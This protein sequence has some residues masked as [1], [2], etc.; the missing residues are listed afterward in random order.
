MARLSPWRLARSTSCRRIAT[1]R[2]P[3]TALVSKRHPARHHAPK[4]SV[5]RLLGSAAA[6]FGERLIAVILTGTGSDGSAGAREVKQAGG[7]VI[8][9]NPTPRRTRLCPPRWHRAPSTLSQIS[10]R[11]VRCSDSWWRAHIP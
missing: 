4:P 6:L 3:T 11:L 10:F 8:I 2:S 9:E 5:D 7:V 1:W